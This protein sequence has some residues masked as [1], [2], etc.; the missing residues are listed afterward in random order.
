L[1]SAYLVATT[2][3]EPPSL[4]NMKILKNAKVYTLNPAQ[5]Q[6][7]A[8]VIGGQHPHRKE[9]V[10]AGNVDKL[11]AEFGHLTETEDLGGKTVLPGLT[12]AHIHIQ[13]YANYLQSVDLFGTDKATGLEKIAARAAETPS[14]GWVIAYGWSQDLWGGKPPLTELDNAVPDHR[15]LLMGVSLHVLWAN[16]AAMKSAGIDPSTPDPPKGII[17]KDGNGTLTGLFYED[18][19]KLFNHVLPD[20]SDE[21]T[22]ELFELAQQ[23]LW[24]KGITGIHDFDRIPSFITL[25]TLHQQGRLKMRVLKNLPVESLDVFIESGLRSGLGDEL[26]R[27]GSIKAFADGA[28][29]AR[30]AAMFAPYD[31]DP[32]NLGMPL[33]DVEDLT[34]FGQKAVANGFSLTVHAIGDAANH[35]MLNGFQQIRAFE[36]INGLPHRRHRLEHVQVLHPEDLHR[37]TEL[38]LIA[39]MQPIH[40]TSDIDMAEAGWGERSRFAY[41]WNTLLENG[42]RLVFGS[43][44]PVD[45]PNPFAGLH[46][47]VTRQR[48]NGYP[49][50]DGWYPTERIGLQQALEA[51]TLGA[52]YTAGLESRLG[53]I[54][55]GYLADLIVLDTDPFKVPPN[56][57][58]DLH[59][60]ATMVGG[61]WVF[62]I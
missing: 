51:Y 52:A 3:Q 13:Q 45:T 6:V 24:Q 22:L 58:K 14:G 54:S 23:D 16:S 29:G 27:I 9:I 36:Q 57:L 42:T 20:P 62:R 50:P 38:D 28:L 39:S 46:A 12:D 43:D 37:L 31:D 18:A 5:P 8:L 1:I 30:T 44:A 59:P 49:H 33:L 48:S 10:S 4:I 11:E 7:D 55:P 61:D 32:E 47:A 26:L 19:M 25:Q 40:A 53:M 56:S 2:S 21:A 17:K 15:V 60:S 35:Q 34:E 41:A